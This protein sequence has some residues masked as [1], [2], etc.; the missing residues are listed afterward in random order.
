VLIIALPLSAAT[1][2]NASSE[3]DAKTVADLDAKYQAAVK[4]NDAATMDDI[5][6]FR[7]CDRARQSLSQS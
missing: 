7:S 5:L 1:N 4:S 2:V 3:K 6:A